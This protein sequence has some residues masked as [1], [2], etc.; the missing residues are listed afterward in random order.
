M[1]L[2]KCKECGKQVSDKAKSCPNCGYPIAVE[3][4]KARVKNET[5]QFKKYLPKIAI[6][7]GVFIVIIVLLTI[8]IFT[9]SSINKKNFIKEYIGGNNDF[10]LNSEWTTANYDKSKG[11]D[12]TMTF[13][14]DY[15]CKFSRTG[16]NFT[17]GNNTYK[18]F[19]TYKDCYYKVDGDIVI[20]YELDFK[21]K[22]ATKLHEFDHINIGHEY[23]SESYGYT[24]FKDGISWG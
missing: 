7:C 3:K 13:N 20:V 2:I 21:K 14:D 1:T 11:I 23:L 12:V 22:E 19:G 8:L 16:G 24:L 4:T 15:T 18:D 17:L 6:A 10:L 9:I 5:D